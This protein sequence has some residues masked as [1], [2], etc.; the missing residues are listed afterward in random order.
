MGNMKKVVHLIASSGLYGAEKW[1]L[2]LMRAMEG[3]AI[4][5][6]LVNFADVR[7]GMSSIV[8]GAQERGLRAVDFYTG[9]YF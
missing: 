8:S 1:I 6:T 7:G 5:S 3:S 9:W 4:D 2:A